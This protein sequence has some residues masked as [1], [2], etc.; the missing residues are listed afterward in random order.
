MRIISGKN[1]GK[2]LIAP[3]SLPVRPTT[4]MAK[5]ALFNILNNH[6][7]FDEITVA[8]LF[9]GIGNISFEFASRGAS[10]ITSVDQ[11]PGCIKFI[12]KIS[13]ELAYQLIT[14]KSD[15]FTFL[16]RTNKKFD[17]IF[18]DPP[19]ELP[20]EKF[21]LLVSLV[22]EKELLEEGGMLVIE[23]AA[24]TDLSPETHFF[25]MKKYGGT[26]FSFFQKE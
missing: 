15:V 10:D 11:N 16:E 23:H 25:Q 18:A 19:Y 17:V 4:D 24:K 6:Y 3:N 7:Y 14:V 21:E 22:F 12:E 2:R 26:C 9:A 13:N 1:K 8:D 5:E 20:K